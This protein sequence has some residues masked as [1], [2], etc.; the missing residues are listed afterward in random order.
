MKK[1][2]ATSIAGLYLGIGQLKPFNP[3]LG[4]TYQGFIPGH[5]I[6]IF[7]EEISHTP[8]KCRFLMVHPTFKFYG[9]WEFVVQLKP[10]KLAMFQDGV[11][12]VDFGNGEKIMYNSPVIKLGGVI[13][14]DRTARWSGVMKFIDEKNGLKAIIRLC[15]G[16]KLGGF[17]SKKRTDSLKGRI[18]T[19]KKTDLPEVFV[20]SSNKSVQRKIDL[21]MDD[22]TQNLADIEGSW[23]QSLIIGD[24]EIWHIDRDKPVFH[25]AVKY[26]LPSDC[27]FREDMTWMKY[28][29]LG[30]AETWK[31]RLEIMMDHEKNKREEY[32]NKK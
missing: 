12:I 4:E 2:I 6:Q 1:V 29:N 13:F 28:G 7:N 25:E 20:R 9:G 17:F 30:Y 16:P 21:K 8:P 26:P 22:I 5:D 19:Y 32:K 31:R 23:L 24:E 3:V 27:R 10:N 11:N 18:Y 15:A 14:G